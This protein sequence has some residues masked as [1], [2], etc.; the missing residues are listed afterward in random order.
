MLESSSCCSLSLWRYNSLFPNSDEKKKSNN[1]PAFMSMWCWEGGYSLLFSWSW[2]WMQWVRIAVWS[3]DDASDW[4]VGLTV[5]VIKHVMRKGQN[6][7]PQTSSMKLYQHFALEAV[8]ADSLFGYGCITSNT[9]PVC[10]CSA[11]CFKNTM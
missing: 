3:P 5:L 6:W 7:H 1:N 10:F 2:T 11:L 4:D 9:V 8:T